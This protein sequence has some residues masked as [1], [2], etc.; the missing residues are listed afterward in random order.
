MRDNGSTAV[1]VVADMS[2]VIARQSW[3]GGWV[4]PDCWNHEGGVKCKRNVF[5]SFNGAFTKGCIFFDG[6]PK[7][8]AE[9]SGGRP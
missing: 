5:I 4:C 9:V 7:T 3:A 1:G 2:E 8:P 6:E